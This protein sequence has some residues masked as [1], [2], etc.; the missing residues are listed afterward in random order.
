MLSPLI[1]EADNLSV[2]LLDLILINIVEPYKSNNKYACHLTQQLL[3]KT[4]DALESTIKM[5]MFNLS[6]N[7]LLLIEIFSVRQFFNRALVMD[8][9]NNKLSITNKIYDIIYELNRTNGELLTSVLPQ[10]ENKLL[11][12]DDA[13]RLSKILGY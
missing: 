13:E 8:K 11:S 10:L 1:T 6:F 7:M 4:G 5:V 12:T 2:E 3:T 9:P